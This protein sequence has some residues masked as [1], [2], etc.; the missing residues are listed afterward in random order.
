MLGQRQIIFVEGRAH[1][2]V[3]PFVECNFSIPIGVGDSKKGAAKLVRLDLQTAN[4]T[5]ITHLDVSSGLER[6][7]PMLSHE[8]VD[9]AK[10]VSTYS[11]N[12]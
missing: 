9:A 7:E 2:A 4:G 1:R 8:H 12:L 10:D 11:K 6:H 5:W 3:A